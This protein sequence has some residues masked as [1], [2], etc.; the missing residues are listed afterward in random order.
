MIDIGKTWED[1]YC[2]LL[3]LFMY[4]SH[5]GIIA[6]DTHVHQRIVR[7]FACV[8]QEVEGPSVLSPLD[9]CGWRGRE[10][11]DKVPSSDSVRSESRAPLRQ[12]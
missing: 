10:E 3:A 11:G 2:P 5:S 8:E 4:C 6:R 7:L 12:A 9:G 1:Q